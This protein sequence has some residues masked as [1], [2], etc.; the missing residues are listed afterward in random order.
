MTDVDD[1]QE[2][3]SSNAAD[4]P[5]S[6]ASLIPFKKIQNPKHRAYL[7]ALSMTPN[8]EKAAKIAG[9]SSAAGYMYRR[10]G[11][12]DF[13]ECLALAREVALE[14]AES[15]AW[16]RAIDGCVEPVF[17]SLGSDP[18][19]GKSLG[20]GQIGTKLNHSDNLLMFMLKGHRP[21]KYRE[22]FEHSGPNG[23]PISVQAVDPR[24]LSSDTLE[25]ILLEAKQQLQLPSAPEAAV[26]AEVIVT[27]NDTTD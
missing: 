11:D 10:D 21:D 1:E 6:L 4:D 27:D 22:R 17:G 9:I 20:T 15:E 8:L 5:R 19:T 18:N 25:R 12:A 26:E 16:R 13:Q 3:Q 24:V 23:G 7:I 14:R 2:Q